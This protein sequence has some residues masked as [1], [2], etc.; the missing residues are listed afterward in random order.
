MFSLWVTFPFQEYTGN[1]VWLVLW[2]FHFSEFLQLSIPHVAILLGRVS[3]PLK[4]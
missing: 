3:E 1:R 4:T 2:L